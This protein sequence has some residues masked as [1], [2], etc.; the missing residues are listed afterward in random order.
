MLGVNDTCQPLDGL[1]VINDEP[2]KKEEIVDPNRHLND[3]PLSDENIE[4]LLRRGDELFGKLSKCPSQ[5]ITLTLLKFMQDLSPT[6]K[7]TGK[8]VGGAAGITYGPQLANQAISALWDIAFP[9]AQPTWLG[10]AWNAMVSFGKGVSQV[11]VTPQINPTMVA[12]C[13]FTGSIALP[14]IFSSTIGICKWASGLGKDTTPTLDSLADINKTLRF[15]ETTKTYYNVKNE[16]LTPGDV[17][18]RANRMREYQLICELLQ[19]KR[20]DVPSLILDHLE[21]IRENKIAICNKKCKT[22]IKQLKNTEGVEQKILDCLQVV[23]KYYSN[24]NSQLISQPNVK[25]SIEFLVDL[26]GLF[27]IPANAKAITFDKK[28]GT[29]CESPS[30]ISNLWHGQS[31]VDLSSHIKNNLTTEIAKRFTLLIEEIHSESTLS[32]FDAKALNS[33]L[34]N[35]EKEMVNFLDS[36]ESTSKN[37]PKK[38]GAHLNST[39]CTVCDDLYN[40]MKA[41]RKMIKDR[42]ITAH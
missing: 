6:A 17:E 15:D 8:A 1:I 24:I 35:L 10:S 18:L 26:Q 37:F 14:V 27:K 39:A 16:P 25:K 28:T 9:K 36:I 41:V 12:L 38:E 4:I 21:G 3:I 13:G 30:K 5:G 31:S 19:A 33:Q 7:T 2:K 42:T 29:F 32:H 20:K 22:L 40:S 23:G 11:A 34:D